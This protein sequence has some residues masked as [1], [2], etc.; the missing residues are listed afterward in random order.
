MNISSLLSMIFLSFFLRASSAAYGGSQAR[1]RIRAVATGICHSHSN[2]RSKPSL[3]STPQ[4]TVPS[5]ARN[6]TCIL[7]DTSQICFCRAMMGIPLSLVKKKLS[8]C[9]IIGK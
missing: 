9:D 4:L 3:Q 8:Q 6:Q 2:A 7:T 5:E 1:D